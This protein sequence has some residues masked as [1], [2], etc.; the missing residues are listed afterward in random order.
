MLTEFLRQRATR[1]MKRRVQTFGCTPAP[2]GE[3]A[4]PLATAPRT[5]RI[6]TATPYQFIKCQSV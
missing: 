6:D 4:Q 3:C 1:I 5:M 2:H